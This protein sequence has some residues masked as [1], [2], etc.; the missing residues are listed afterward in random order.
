MLIKI[1]PYKVGDKAPDF[2][3]RR[4]NQNNDSEI[5]RLSDLKGKGIMLNFW[6]TNCKPCE[7]EM[8]FIEELYP[9]YKDIEI[10]A[11]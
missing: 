5:I 2:Q 7:I 4:I 11:V 10:I 6:A 9:Q 3:L 1:T 8:P